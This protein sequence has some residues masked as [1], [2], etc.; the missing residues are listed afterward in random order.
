MNPDGNGRAWVAKCKWANAKHPFWC[1]TAF[2]RLGA[3]WPV[4]LFTSARAAL[5]A[6]ARGGRADG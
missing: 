4:S 1:G 2:L 6:L 3:S 5:T